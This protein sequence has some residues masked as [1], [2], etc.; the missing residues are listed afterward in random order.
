M[1]FRAN[2][3]NEYNGQGKIIIYLQKTVNINNIRIRRYP[4]I[5]IQ[6]DI[7]DLLTF[8]VEID[9]LLEY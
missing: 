8:D 9:E 4:G 2:P 3:F 7:L 5:D 6:R 1:G